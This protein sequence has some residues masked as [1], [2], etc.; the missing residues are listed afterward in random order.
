MGAKDALKIRGSLARADLPV[1]D[2]SRATKLRSRRDQDRGEAQ[3]TKSGLSD[4]FLD[5]GSGLK[6]KFENTFP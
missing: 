6:I 3:W 2:F 1:P 4:N 5:K